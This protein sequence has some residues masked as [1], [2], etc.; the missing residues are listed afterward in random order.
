[1][2]PYRIRPPAAPKHQKGMCVLGQEAN[3]GGGGGFASNPFPPP[4]ENWVVATSPYQDRAGWP[5]WWLC[6]PNI[7]GGGSL[8][9]SLSFSRVCQAPSPDF[10]PPSTRSEQMGRSALL[11][12]AQRDPVV[13][14]GTRRCLHQ[15]LPPPP[16]PSPS[17]GQD[18]AERSWR[19]TPLSGHAMLLMR[20]RMMRLRQDQEGGSMAGGGWRPLPTLAPSAT[21][22]PA[23]PSM[24]S[25][26]C[27]LVQQVCQVASGGAAS[28]D[29]SCPPGGSMGYCTA[30]E[31]CDDNR[32]PMPCRLVFFACEE[33]L[34]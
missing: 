27:L 1:M 10:P 19:S 28:S 17:Q 11:G 16:P 31:R 5:G 2:L 32:Q 4:K 29:R 13:G 26:Y 25:H 8:S 34:S 7:L 21:A 22:A 14:I 33:E 9:L 3:R 23:V 30:Q 15:A 12:L 18:E 24:L 20:R 6:S